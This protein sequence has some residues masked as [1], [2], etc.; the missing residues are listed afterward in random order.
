VFSKVEGIIRIVPDPVSHRIVK[1][2]SLLDGG[3][4]A[5]SG[6]LLRVRDGLFVV[7]VNDGGGT[8]VFIIDLVHSSACVGLRCSFGFNAT[9]RNQYNRENQETS[10]YAVE[11]H[12]FLDNF[13]GF[14]L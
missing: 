12:F 1:T 13:L 5:S 11:R 2:D 3:I 7:T 8:K 10:K 6:F 4:A 14:Q 9:T